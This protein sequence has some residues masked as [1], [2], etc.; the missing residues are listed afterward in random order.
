MMIL[1]HYQISLCWTC[2]LRY[3]V[4]YNYFSNM[5]TS[6]FWVYCRGNIPKNIH[7][8][9]RL[10]NLRLLNCGWFERGGLV[11]LPQYAENRK[12]GFSK[13]K[14]GRISVSIRFEIFRLHLYNSYM[15]LRWNE[16]ILT[17]YYA[18]EKNWVGEHIY[19]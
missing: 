15:A 18:S 3:H 16:P 4:T 2:L 9:L 7:G 10:T 14:S 19:S 8:L 1:W 6:S 11:Q 5:L 13:Q 17:D 12:I